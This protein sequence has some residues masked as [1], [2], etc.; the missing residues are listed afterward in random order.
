MRS[1]GLAL[2][3]LLAAPVTAQDDPFL[4]LEDVE[5]DSA[6]AWVES[7]NA[8]TLGAL[9]AGP[10]FE[11]VR[12]RALALLTTDERIA[13]PSIRGA[14]LYNFWTDAENPR[15]LWRR[16]SWDAYLAGEPDWQTLLDIDRLAEAEGVGWSFAG[17]TCLAPDYTRCLV[18]LSRGGADAS[19]TREFD[20]EAQAFVEGG[21]FLPEAKGAAAW[22][23]ENTLLVATDFGP[24]ST[25]TSG[26]P[27]LVKRWTR[28]TPLEEAETVFEGEATD[29]GA[30]AASFRRGGETV[31]VVVH[32][33]AFFETAYHVLH[34]GQFVR[35]DLPLDA[36]PGLVGE[37]LTVY[38]RSD[39]ETGG[40]T[41]PA[42]TLLAVDYDDFLAGG[43]DFE[44]VF[45]PT[46]RQTIQ[47]TASTDS[48]VLVSVLDN[49]AGRLLRFRHDG[50]RWAEDE[51]EAP[52]LGSVNVVSTSED[53]DRFFF[54]YSSFVQPSTL[55]LAEADG[56]VQEV[57][58][59]P[60]QFDAAGLVVEQH[61]ATSD[62]GTAV[63]YF[64]VRR[65]DVAL[66]GQSPT[67]LYGYGGFEV[68][69]A[70]SYN[71][72][73]GSAWLER[74][75]VYAL[76]NIRGGGEFGPA[77]HR[78]AQRENRQRAFDDFIAVAEDLVG[79]GVT[80]PEHLGI[81]GG[82]NGGLLVGAAMTQRPD[83][84]D[85]VVVSVP[86]LDMRRYH[87]LLAG[88]SWMAEY[89]DPDD[90]DD[91]AFIREY[92]PYHNVRADADYPVPLFTT[93]TRDDRVHPGHARKMAA[94]M[95]SMGYPVRYF[96][97]TEGGHGAGVTPEQRATAAAVTYSY[98]WSRLR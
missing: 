46:G 77:W 65:D 76:A 64:L 43:R 89:G 59:L 63:P 86:L 32:R 29:V 37:H 13:Y 42:G 60:A 48:Y 36:D 24:A 44:T 66:D 92:S 33:P 56:S 61:E 26:Y 95:E 14:W 3:L 75:G 25:T 58:A 70:P 88:A 45:A 5:G 83:L 23:D 67:L 38:L 96:E 94:L 52:D 74:G 54:V 22:V 35:L 50:E 15:G 93:T 71:E 30:W 9:R 98:L 51:V 85:A 2:L 73:V 7:R 39:W 19:E 31:P 82:S 17:S 53:D 10:D 78:A 90:P 18:R 4:W 69:L 6:L 20:V 87:K 80:S 28:G 68:A 1:A 49:V 21:F 62:D 79:R 84:F 34:G 41:Y 47:S 12:D 97:N 72:L 11:A 91:W 27:R 16:T 57:A 40:R 55:Y 81:M 8:E